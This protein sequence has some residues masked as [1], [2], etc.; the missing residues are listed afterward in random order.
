MQTF[1]NSVQ[2]VLILLLL[3]G[4]GYLCAAQGYFT[5]EAKSFLS[6]FLLQI[7][8]PF[9]CIYS[10]RSRLTLD[11]LKEAGPMLLVP[12]INISVCF[13]LSF[14]AAKLLKLKHKSVGPFMMMCGLSN[15]MFIGFPMCTELFG[16]E[17]TS[18]VIMYYMVST[19]FTQM[20][21]IPLIR[22]S[23]ESDKKLSFGA[24]AKK[25]ITTPAI[26]GIIVGITVVLLD[27]QPP[28]LFMSYGKYMN[29]L[30]TPLAML[31]TGRI[32]YEVGLKNLRFDL[33]QIFVMLFRFIISPAICFFLCSA[34]GITGMALNVFIIQAAMPVVTL[35]VVAASEYEADEAMAAQGAALSTLLCFV[36]IPALTML[37][38]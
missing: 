36:V 24:M 15:T 16:Q 13:V 34:V 11:M 8:V 37:L 33:P 10:L 29:Q 23:G 20:V 31:V 18:F 3:A 5:K 32:I 9:M 22:W 21:G 4:T 12:L 1:L 27:I 38:T 25:I 30:V 2:S 7:V 6:K 28:A 26:I 19:C 17:C 14:F 35:T